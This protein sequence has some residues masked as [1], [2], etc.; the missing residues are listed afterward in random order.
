MQH[1]VNRDS[2]VTT[3]TSAAGINP[4]HVTQVGWWEHPRFD[5]E[6]FL[7]AAELVAFEVLDPVLRSRVLGPARAKQALE[8]DEGFRRTMRSMFANEPTG[9]LPIPT[10]QD[11]M[12]RLAEIE[13]RL[14][15]LERIVARDHP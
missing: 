11:A 5:E 1:L 8:E 14:A 10:L 13:R 6:R 2:S 9:V 3:G 7:E 4:D 12:T 15:A